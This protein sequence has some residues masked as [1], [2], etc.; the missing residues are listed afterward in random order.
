[1]N[2]KEINSLEITFDENTFIGTEHLTESAHVIYVVTLESI[3]N[4]MKI[5]MEKR[6]SVEAFEHG[7]N[8]DLVEAPVNL[9]NYLEVEMLVRGVS[10]TPDTLR[11]HILCSVLNSWG[12]EYNH[13]KNGFYRPGLNTRWLA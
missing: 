11:F 2:Q 4:N 7:S 12:F 10:K 6:F 3:R 1:M 9:E 13:T 8:H 5:F